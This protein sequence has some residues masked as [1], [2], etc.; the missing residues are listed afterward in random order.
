VFV[1]SRYNSDSNIGVN[2]S[3]QLVFDLSSI[4]DTEAVTASELQLTYRPTA[5]VSATQ[6]SVVRV[7]P[8]ADLVDD[9]TGHVAEHLL[10]VQTLER[11]RCDDSAAGCS[12]SL[13]VTT[14]AVQ[15]CGGHLLR[16]RIGLRSS[17]WS[18]TSLQLTEPPALIVY[19]YDQTQV[20]LGRLVV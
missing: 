8:G 10:D 15:L 5:N 16:L 14:A 17:S 20:G 4:P 19:T 12:L 7:R 3:L 11:R 13:D 2:S 18:S 6:L 1:D 9:G